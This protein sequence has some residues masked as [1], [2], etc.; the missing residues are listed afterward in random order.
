MANEET[1]FM[2]LDI[3]ESLNVTYWLDGGGVDAL[4]G[5]QTREHR[6]VDI[7]FDAD[8]TNEV[9]SKL[10]EI[11]YVVETDCMPVRVELA[12]PQYGYLDIHP[13]VIDGDT[14]KQANP[15]GCYW[16]FSQNLFGETVYKGKRIPC[17]SLEGQLLFHSGYEPREQDLHDMGLLRELEKA[18]IR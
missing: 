6:D 17:I 8:K 4:Y 9:L 1:L 10:K 18:Q 11:G 3:F 14:V 7:N 5:K 15:E 2:I 12:H 16:E 13:F